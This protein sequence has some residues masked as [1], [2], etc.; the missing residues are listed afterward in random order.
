MKK[1]VMILFASMLVLSC[2]NGEAEKKAAEEEAAKV[3]MMN[4]EI[5]EMD[6]ISEVLEQ[7][8]ADIEAASAELKNLLNEL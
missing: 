5:H 1:V 2:G 8:T 3:E 4:A 7:T 6:S